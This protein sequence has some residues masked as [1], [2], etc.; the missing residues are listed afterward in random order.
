[1]LINQTH[2]ATFSANLNQYNSKTHAMK[3][4]LFILLFVSSF[5]LKLK[6]QTEFIE[7]RSEANPLYWK[8]RKPFTDYWQ[9][10]VHYNI[11][12]QLNDSSDIITGHEELIYFNNSPKIV[13]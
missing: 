2:K 11:S 13:P 7:Y 4:L 5:N 10:D 12:A 8:N 1:M 9:Q 6:S 3:L